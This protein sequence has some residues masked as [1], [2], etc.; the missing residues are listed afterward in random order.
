MGELSELLPI[1]PN[2]YLSHIP[3]SFRYS[4]DI[5]ELSMCAIKDELI[6]KSEE[7][8]AVI[9]TFPGCSFNPARVASLIVSCPSPDVARNLT[10]TINNKAIRGVSVITSVLFP[11]EVYIRLGL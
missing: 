3:T 1:F 9:D 5:Q 11:M 4:P 7:V 8:Q 10:Q 6:N 2:P